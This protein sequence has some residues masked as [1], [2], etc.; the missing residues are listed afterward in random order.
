[1]VEICIALR[2]VKQQMLDVAGSQTA[3]ILPVL[4]SDPS[5]L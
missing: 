1:M 5:P 2:P 3:R 4:V